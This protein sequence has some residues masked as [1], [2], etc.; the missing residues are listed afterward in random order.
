MPY[1]S[2]LK[3]L[4]FA[5][6]DRVIYVPGIADGDPKHPACER[7]AVSSISTTTVFVRFD[8]QVQKLGWHQTTAQGCDPRDLVKE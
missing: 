2:D 8:K 4:D 1:A 5:P 3:P 6:G 7:G